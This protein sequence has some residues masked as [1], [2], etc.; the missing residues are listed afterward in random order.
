LDTCANEKPKYAN[1][2]ITKRKT[3]SLP[4]NT[5]LKKLLPHIQDQRSSQWYKIS[6]TALCQTL[7]APLSPL[8]TTIF[9]KYQR[10]FLQKNLQSTL[11][12]P[13]SKLLSLCRPTLSV[14]PI[15]WLPMTRMERSRCIIW[16]LG[17]LPGGSPRLCSCQ[18]NKLTKAHIIQYL[19][20]QARLRTPRSISDPVSHLLNRLSQKP[21]KNESTKLYWAQQWKILTTILQEVDDIQHSDS[22][23][24]PSPLATHSQESPFIKWLN[25]LDS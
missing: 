10:I 6:K 7:P 25:P 16:R 13:H 5:L 9:H 2:K 23:L 1:R 14:D 4:S 3:L 8:H 17:W 11:Q 18:R 20:I 22:P 24:I 15:I 12:K 19:H 21:P